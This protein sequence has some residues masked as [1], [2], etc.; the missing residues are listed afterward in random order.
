LS[1]NNSKKHFEGNL[2]KRTL[3]ITGLQ[4]HLE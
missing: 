2:V 3:K 1:P 4:R